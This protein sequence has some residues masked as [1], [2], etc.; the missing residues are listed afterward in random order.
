[1]SFAYETVLNYPT[2]DVMH[3]QQT[4][5]INQD[6]EIGVCDK[7]G[8]KSSS[9][10]RRPQY[11]TTYIC[12]GW[13]LKFDHYSV[14]KFEN[15]HL[16]ASF[17]FNFGMSKFCISSDHPCIKFWQLKS[18]ANISVSKGIS[19][20]IC[21]NFNWYLKS[22]LFQFYKTI[23]NYSGWNLF[24]FMWCLQYCNFLHPFL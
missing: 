16:L 7:M 22:S 9:R 4:P 1:M 10:C 15:I 14:W 12:T 24:T 13:P 2:Y 11:K 17:Q 5:P 21:F 23:I 19:S 20:T 6:G 8:I 18:S 3:G